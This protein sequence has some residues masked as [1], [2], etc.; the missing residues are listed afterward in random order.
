MPDENDKIIEPEVTVEKD[1]PTPPDEAT[2]GSG[3]CGRYAAESTAD[4]PLRPRH[5][6]CPAGPAGRQRRAADGGGAPGHRSPSRGHRPGHGAR[7]RCQDDPANLH[8]RRRCAKIL[9]ILHADDESIH[10]IGQCLERFVIEEVIPSR[11]MLAARVR[12]QY[13]P[14]LSGQPGAQGLFDRDHRHAQGT[15]ADQPLYSEEIKLFLNRSSMDD[16]GGWPTS[17][18]T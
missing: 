11:R 14:E 9:K 16:P 12:Y 5:A 8:N 18:P 4:H 2:E 6:S 15:G 7:Y 10:V 17:P 13:A 3:G 1:E